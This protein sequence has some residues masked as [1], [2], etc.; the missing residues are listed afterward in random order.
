MKLSTERPP[1]Y[2]LFQQFFPGFEKHQPIFCY[3]DTIYNPFDREVTPDLVAHEAIHSK[4]QGNNPEFWY[5]RY[6]REPRFRLEQEVEAYKTQYQIVKKHSKDR[7]LNSWF[8]HQL[9]LDL[10]SPLYG[11]LVTQQEAWRLIRG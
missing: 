2:H 8:L 6:F 7:E 11:N 1:N 4:Q 10:A 9:S 5:S 3:G